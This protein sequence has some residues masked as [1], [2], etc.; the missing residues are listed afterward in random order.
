MIK[1]ASIRRIV[2]ASFALLIVLVSLYIFPQKEIKIPS[3]IIYKKAETNAIYLEDQNKLISRT[4]INVDSTDKEQLAN[5]LIMALINN[6]NKSKYLPLGFSSTILGDVKIKEIKIENDV[7]TVNFDGNIFK[8]NENNEEKIIESIVYTLTEIEG[9]KKIKILINDEVLKRL[10][11]SNKIIPEYLD[12][13]IGINRISKFNSLKNTQDVTAYFIGKNN[14]D[15]YFV[16][17]TFTTDSE[18]EK[19]EIIIKELSGKDFIDDNLSTYISA[20]VILK[21]YEILENEIKLEFN[22][23][24]FNGFNEIDEEVMYGIALSIYD[25]YNIS[26]VRFEVDQRE[27]MA[28]ALKSS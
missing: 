28:Y 9:I 6:S 15:Y 5:E 16:P 2:V 3:K 10:P 22:N 24:I 12:R 11:S 13:S 26:T 7:I 23:E 4:F 17:V 18:K 25:N 1:K 14:G 8:D 20:G 19:I 21:N 27:I